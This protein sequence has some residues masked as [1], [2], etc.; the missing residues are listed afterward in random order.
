MLNGGG[1]LERLSQ[2]R[3]HVIDIVH[4]FHRGHQR[5]EGGGLFINGL[6]AIHGFHGFGQSR[7]GLFASSDQ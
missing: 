1:R 7:L 6:D 3:F 5:T 4:G 2:H